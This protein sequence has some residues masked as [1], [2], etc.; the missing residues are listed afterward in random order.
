M[1]GEI[2]PIHLE[3]LLEA[4]ESVRVVDIRSPAAFERSHIP[5]SENVPFDE[6][7]R[8]IDDFEGASHVVTVCPHGEASLQAARLIESFEGVSPDARIES[9]AG[10]IESWPGDLVSGEPAD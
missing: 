2:D 9:L 8:A 1:P 7:T 3:S 5:D 6:L 4:G 10:G